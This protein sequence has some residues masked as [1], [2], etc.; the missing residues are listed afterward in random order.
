MNRYIIQASLVSLLVLLFACEKD[1]LEYDYA[2]DGTLSEEQVFS[3]NE[4]ARNFLNSSYR[5]LVENTNG[6]FRYSLSGELGLS[7]GSDEAVSAL[8]GA[9]INAFNN[10][11]WSPTLLFDDLYAQQYRALRMVNIFLKNAPTSAIIDDA[12]LSKQ[13]LIGEA[14]FLRA[15][16][17]FELLKRYG[18]IIIADRPFEL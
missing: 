12:T 7:T 9:T 14:H 6:N 10:G 3:S 11:N 4:H 18:G 16:F 13:S 8:P 15:M 2:V 5:G 17:H 1:F